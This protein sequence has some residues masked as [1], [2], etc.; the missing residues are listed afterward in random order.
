MSRI[1]YAITM[2]DLLGPVAPRPRW[3]RK[4]FIHAYYAGQQARHDGIDAEENPYYNAAIMRPTCDS[5][6]TKTWRYYWAEAWSRGWHA[7]HL[8]L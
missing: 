7:P 1:F 6:G 2:R 4:P 5:D 8:D 3:L